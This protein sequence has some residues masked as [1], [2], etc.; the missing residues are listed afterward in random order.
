[1]GFGVFGESRGK[2]SRA[3][4]A[5]V[6]FGLSGGKKSAPPPPS[7]VSYGGAKA[8]ANQVGGATLTIPLVVPSV[9][10]SFLFATVGGWDGGAPGTPAVTYHGVPMTLIKDQLGGDASM[11]VCLYGLANPIVGAGNAVY[12]FAGAAWEVA[13][14]VALYQGVKQV[15][16]IGTPVGAN[17]PN[18]NNLSVTITGANVHNLVVGALTH[19]VA[20]TAVAPVGGTILR[21]SDSCPPGND[22]TVYSG[23]LAVNLAAQAFGFSWT[24]GATGSV[25]AA[26]VELLVG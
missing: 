14:T 12:T 15:G 5:G 17:A 20:A 23:E 19:W 18:Q 13:A 26:A 10:H 21:D 16:S 6:T 22:E 4:G 11:R 3:P 1:M 2:M 25:A 9:V 7:S 24:A 8:H